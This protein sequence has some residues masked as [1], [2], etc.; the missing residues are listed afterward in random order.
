MR[1]LGIDYGTKRTGV[2][3]SDPDARMAVVKETIEAAFI[4]HDKTLTTEK[5]LNTVKETKSISVTLKEQIDALK[6]VFE[7]HDFKAAN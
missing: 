1:Y 4:S 2:A 6:K 3:I 7:K 5:I